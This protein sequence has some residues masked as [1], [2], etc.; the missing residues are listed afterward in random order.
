MH[1]SSVTCAVLIWLC[2]IMAVHCHF[3]NE[4]KMQDTIATLWLL[5]KDLGIV[6]SLS[7]SGWQ[8]LT[9]TRLQAKAT[10]KIGK[11]T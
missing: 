9:L 5:E 3:L 2:M 8:H 1:Y 6:D 7:R 10:Q 11:Q 4:Y